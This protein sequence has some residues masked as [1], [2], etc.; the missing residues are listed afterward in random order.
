MRELRLYADSADIAQIEP[1]L[2][3]GLIAGVTTN[4]TI[5]RRCG[6][7][8]ADQAALAERWQGAGA[9]ELFFQVVGDDTEAMLAD[10]YRIAGMGAAVKVPATR[11]GYAVVA[12]LA[13]E[14]IPT[15][16]TA[17]YTPA[18]AVYAGAVGATYIAPYLGRM[19]D[20]GMD[21]FAVIAEMVRVLAHTE[22]EALVASVRTPEDVA[23][24]ALDGVTRITAAPAV[25]TACMTNEVSEDSARV[26]AEDARA[27]G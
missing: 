26:F 2:R 3:D 6:W 15:L 9:A 14:G 19:N 10:A 4:P 1:L 22:T 8:A 24:L 12:R 25:L 13:R 21:G 27:A 11:D 18:Q 20:R 5:L 7:R 16:L 23:R 17:V